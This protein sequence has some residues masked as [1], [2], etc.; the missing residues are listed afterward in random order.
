[1]ARDGS[2]SPNSN[3]NRYFKK[4]DV[5][6]DL[7]RV[8]GLDLADASTQFLQEAVNALSEEDEETLPMAVEK[9]YAQVRG[10]LL[11]SMGYLTTS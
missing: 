7:G 11:S 9:R 3:S 6:K 8:L 5:A 10:L 1:M 2:P 4:S